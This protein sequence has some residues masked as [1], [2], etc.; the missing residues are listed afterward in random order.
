M[1]HALELK[2]SSGRAESSRFLLVIEWDLSL[3]TGY[4]I[5]ERESTVALLDEFPNRLRVVSPYPAHPGL[6]FDP[7]IDYVRSHK[8]HHPFHY[9]LFLFA[10]WRKIKRIIAEERPAAVV[11]RPGPVPVIPALT[12]HKGHAVILKKLGGYRRMEARNRPWKMRCVS[13]AAKPLFRYI[14]GNC[15]GA[16][17]ESHAYAEWIPMTF[18]LPASRLRYIPNAANTRFFMPMDRAWARNKHG[19]QGFRYLAGYVGAV[20]SLRSIDLAVEAA[21]RLR[22]IPNLGFVFVGTGSSVEAL[23][24]EVVREGLEHR[25]LF[26]GFIPYADIPSVISAFDIALDLTRVPFAI[27]SKTVIG[28][29]SQKIAQYLACGVPVVAWTTEDTTFLDEHRLG[30]TV[31]PGDIDA[32]TEVLRDLFLTMD[33][34]RSIGPRAREFACNELSAE[35][36]A[37]R[38]MAFWEDLAQVV[39]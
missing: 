29:Y 30:A 17:V 12:L 27:G 14:T 34:D 19:W 39:Q 8:R 13:A 5:N 2:R 11:F 24:R 21:F 33:Q 23:R 32:L 10:A 37:R 31:P 20:D 9:P 26:P 18:D 28:S 4:S 6:F 16:D 7:R 3:T 25:I 36:I 22:D 1:S 38:R 35:V 15:V